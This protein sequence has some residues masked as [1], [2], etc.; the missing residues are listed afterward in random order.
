VR[1]AALNLK[2][3]GL[4]LAIPAV[5]ETRSYQ[6]L[7]LCASV[8]WAEIISDKRAG[9][10]G[11]IEVCAGNAAVSNLH[12]AQASMIAAKKGVEISLRS[13]S[14]AYQRRTEGKGSQLDVFD[15]GNQLTIAR[16]TYVRSEYQYLSAIAQ[17]Q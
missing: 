8:A 15:A 17:Y 6:L 5:A 14:E 13:F 4:R 3:T 9:I 2:H 11:A 10:K 1:R 12:R 16:S 7:S